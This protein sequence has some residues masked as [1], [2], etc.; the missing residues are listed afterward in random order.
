MKIFETQKNA[1]N[2][3]LHKFNSIEILFRKNVLPFRRK[4]IK[5]T[6]ITKQLKIKNLISF[7]QLL[8]SERKLIQEH[9]HLC[10]LLLTFC[11]FLH[12]QTNVILSFHSQFDSM[13]S[14]SFS[15][16]LYLLFNYLLLIFI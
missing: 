13:C 2:R 6:H 10:A 15:F 1:R 9:T 12:F 5:Y 4:V 11:R 3:K 8:S 14:L 16:S 7:L